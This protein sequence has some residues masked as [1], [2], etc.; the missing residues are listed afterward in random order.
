MLTSTA[1]PD[2]ST[3]RT[4]STPASTPSAP[5]FTTTPDA[6]TARRGSAGARRRRS[7]RVARIARRAPLRSRP[8]VAVLEPHDVLHLGRR[9]LEHV[10]VGDGDHP[11]LHARLDVVAVAR[12]HPVLA[13]PVALVEDEDEL[14]RPEV[15]RLVLAL[16]VLEREAV[17]RLDVQDL[18][19]VTIRESPPQLVAPGLLDAPRPLERLRT[20]AST[21]HGFYPR[22]SKLGRGS[23]RA[24]LRPDGF[25]RSAV[26]KRVA[27][28]P[29]EAP[30]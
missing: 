22:E 28:S 27:H 26:R 8:T 17:S 2:A 10:A 15:D 6:P 20:D 18:A 7:R 14:P 21:L 4:P 25:A 24:G 5:R 16:V 30:G 11:V 13:Q 12:L 29:P 3:S 9:D 19:H 23:A 1:S